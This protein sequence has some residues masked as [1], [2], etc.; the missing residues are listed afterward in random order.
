MSNEIK[1][2]AI[3]CHDHTLSG[4]NR[5]LLDWITTANRDKYRII[6]V[7]PRKNEQ[8][9]E[10]CQKNNI[11]VVRGNYFV[12]FKYLYKLSL[13]ENIKNIVKNILRVFINP[14]SFNL[15]KKKLMKRDIKI[16]HSNSFATTYGVKLAMKMKIPHL[17]HIREFMEEDHKIAHFESKKK[18]NQYCEYAFIVFTF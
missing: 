12:T 5:S 2:V 6:C 11:E 7:I 9:E 15:L 4:A 8:F 1:N 3:I 17:W 14:F 13:K 10:I 16:I 18:I